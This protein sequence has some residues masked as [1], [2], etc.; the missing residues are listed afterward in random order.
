MGQGDRTGILGLSLNRGDAEEP[1]WHKKGSNATP[2]AVEEEKTF[3]RTDNKKAVLLPGTQIYTV[4]MG[5]PQ[6]NPHLIWDNRYSPQ[7]L[8]DC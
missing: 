2:L 8:T 4:H 1:T 7:L 5:E 3:L 6:F